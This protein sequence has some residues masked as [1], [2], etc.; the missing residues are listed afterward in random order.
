MNVEA[1]CTGRDGAASSLLTPEVIE[2]CHLLGDT[3]FLSKLMRTPKD[4]CPFTGHKPPF[5]DCRECFRNDCA[6]SPHL[7]G[8]SSETYFDGFI[9]YYSI[10][11]TPFL[12]NN[13][14]L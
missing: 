12:G 14:R 1:C 3:P 9:S 4:E 7:T 5:G 6:L 2:F 13:D 8:N 11:D 10:G